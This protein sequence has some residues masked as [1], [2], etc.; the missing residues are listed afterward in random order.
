MFFILSLIMACQHDNPLPIFSETPSITI[1]AE[2]QQQRLQEVITATKRT[3]LEGDKDQALLIFQSYYVNEFRELVPQL[4]ALGIEGLAQVQYDV[5]VFMIDI[6]TIE[7]PTKFE[8]RLR[9]QAEQ[10][11]TLFER[12]PVPSPD[13]SAAVRQ[14]SSTTL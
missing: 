2:A 3:W 4:Q 14:S 5:G 12:I 6:P 9:E 11:N 10:L 7:V 1:Q 13:A 8:S